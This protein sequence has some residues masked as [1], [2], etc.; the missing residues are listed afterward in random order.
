MNIIQRPEVFEKYH[1]GFERTRSIRIVVIHGT[2][3]G[4][5]S[6]E[7]IDGWILKDTFE[8]AKAYRNGEGFNYNIDYDGTIN[9]FTDPALWWHYHSSTWRGLQDRQN[10]YDAYT[11][12]IELMNPARWNDPLGPNGAPYTGPQYESLFELLMAKLLP[13]NPELCTISGHGVIQRKYIGKYKRCPG[14]GFNWDALAT[15]LRMNHYQCDTGDECIMNIV[16]PV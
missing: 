11:V 16:R 1:N 12:G 6:H 10:E 8:R 4:A 7:L 2:E 14:P 13:E 15:A 5:S 3:G 9:Q